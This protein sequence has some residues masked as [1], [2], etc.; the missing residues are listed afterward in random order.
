MTP[1]IDQKRIKACKPLDQCQTIATY[2]EIATVEQNLEFLLA[3]LEMADNVP[4]NIES[5]CVPG[6]YN[7]IQLQLDALYRAS[8]IL[9]PEID[10]I[11]AEDIQKEIEIKNMRVFPRS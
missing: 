11:E 1:K 4:Q 3:F 10:K 5:Y 6:M 2:I 7:L 9:C 8:L